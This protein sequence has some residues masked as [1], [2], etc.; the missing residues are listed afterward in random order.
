MVYKDEQV[1]QTTIPI[2]RVNSANF[3]NYHAQ[4]NQQTLTLL[5][6]FLNDEKLC[7]SCYIWGERGTGKS[8]LLYASCKQIPS[9]VYI[10]L[11][12]LQLQPDVLTAVV[13]F[14][15]VCIDDIDA[16]ACQTDWES[17]LLILL[18]NT[19]Q[20]GNL[21]VL[22]GNRPPVDLHFESNDLVNRLQGRR[23]FKLSSASDQTKVRMLVDRANERGLTVEPSVA[24]FILRR[25]A[26]DTHSLMRLFDR[27]ALA[28]LESR[29][30]ITIPFL[31]ELDEFKFD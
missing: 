8:H 16:V 2:D 9:S 20:N 27:V 3:S 21:L 12:D 15:L 29:R 18:E 28:S 10:P 4:D 5:Q 31:R 13:K 17:Q 30:R 23:V 11:L 22:T 26:R 14:R 24:E 19:E 6:D 1:V 7:G 25:H